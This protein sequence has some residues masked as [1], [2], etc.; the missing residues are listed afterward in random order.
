MILGPLELLTEQFD[1]ENNIILA[2]RNEEWS[3]TLNIS[4]INCVLPLNNVSS[5][6]SIDKTNPIILLANN[7]LITQLNDLKGNNT[8][9]HPRITLC[10]ISHINNRL[11][12]INSGKYN[13][14]VK[15][16]ENG[17]T[18]KNS[19]NEPLY[20]CKLVKSK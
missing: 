10:E 13:W 7:D 20:I 3:K 14:E 8:T 12:I 16:M 17:I 9:Q 15:K 4:F 11:N 6:Q 1:N 19:S 18:L 2:T 5:F